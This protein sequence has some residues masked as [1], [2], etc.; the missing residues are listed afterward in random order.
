MKYILRDK[1]DGQYYASKGDPRDI[2][3]GRFNATIE[4]AYR[5]ENEDLAKFVQRI[6]E[7][8]GFLPEVVQT[9]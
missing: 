8:H 4:D 2:R 7:N 3:D 1:E 5:F 9:E 6:L